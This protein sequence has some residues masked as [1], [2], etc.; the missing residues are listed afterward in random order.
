MLAASGHRPDW[1]PYL[2]LLSTYSGQESDLRPWLK[3]AEINR[4]GN[5]RLQYMAGLALNINR[6]GAI[7]NEILRYRRFPNN[8]FTGSEEHKRPLR[9]ALELAGRTGER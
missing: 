2:A 4:D 8:L 1:R 6:E 5:L 7:Y 9:Y 3:G